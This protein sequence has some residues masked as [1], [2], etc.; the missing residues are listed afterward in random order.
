[1]GRVTVSE[2]KDGLSE[3]INRAAYGP[4]RILILSRGKP[5]AAMI[6]MADLERF[7]DLEDAQA[8]R[9]ALAAYRA[10]ETVPYE[11]FRADLVTEGL[12]D[13]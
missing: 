13:E 8:A 1:M 9:E 3:F 2:L 7:E 5:K 10:G 4:E 12:L 11:Q 6:S